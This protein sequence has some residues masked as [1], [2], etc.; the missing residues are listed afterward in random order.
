MF[1]KI[2]LRYGH[3]P[4]IIELRDVSESYEEGGRGEVYQ[5]GDIFDPLRMVVS[6]E[7]EGGG[8]DR[9]GGTIWLLLSNKKKRRERL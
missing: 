5:D 4:N 1:P 9:L 2:L 6:V 7:G 3:H 8:S